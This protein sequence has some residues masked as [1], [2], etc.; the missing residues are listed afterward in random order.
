M[1]PA[2]HGSPLR[3][4]PPG[5]LRLG[6]RTEPTRLRTA[7]TDSLVIHLSRKMVDA[8][9]GRDIALDFAVWTGR[10]GL[11]RLLRLLSW[12]TKPC[13][14]V[15]RSTINARACSPRCLLCLQIGLCPPLRLREP[16]TGARRPCLNEQ[17]RYVVPVQVTAA[18]NPAMRPIAQ[19]N[20]AQRLPLQQRAR[21]LRCPAPAGPD[22][23]IGSGALFGLLGRVD[24]AQTDPRPCNFQRIAIDHARLSGKFGLRG[25]DRQSKP[26]GCDYGTKP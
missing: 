13:N 4:S 19:I 3:A 17:R 9:V 26:K 2:L 25:P 6:L 20:A 14:R 10:R 11:R 1:R 21:L 5:S 23:A 7:H 12:R 18:H 15:Q 22:C 16:Q 24:P 8:S